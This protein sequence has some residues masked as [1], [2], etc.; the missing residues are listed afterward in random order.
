MDT[1]KILTI[2]ILIG[3]LLGTVAINITSNLLTNIVRTWLVNTSL[4][5]NKRRVDKLRKELND[6]TKIY[7]DTKGLYLRLF[8]ALFLTLFF[9]GFGLAFSFLIV[10]A[11]TINIFDKSIG[12]LALVNVGT[13]AL[14]MSLWNCWWQIKFI[15]RMI[16]FDAYRNMTNG[17]IDRM[18]K[19]QNSLPKK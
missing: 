4:A 16:H 13:F 19:K 12:G 10:T 9:F 3:T 1:A 7:N 14:S 5:S 8:Y 11:L 6:H 17:K 18:I 2:G 15:L